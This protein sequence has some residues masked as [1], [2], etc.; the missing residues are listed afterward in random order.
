[1][2]FE[3]GIVSAVCSFATF[4]IGH[5]MG[6]VAF[7][8]SQHQLDIKAAKALRSLRALHDNKEYLL[9]C[10]ERMA[11]AMEESNGK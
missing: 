4:F 3:I 8:A 11:D 5:S 2:T 10:L 7:R 1:M 9:K 6:V